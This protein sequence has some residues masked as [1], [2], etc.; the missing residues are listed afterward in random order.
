M[1][2]EP[3]HKQMN[4]LLAQWLLSFIASYS[5]KTLLVFIVKN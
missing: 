2:R 1:N 4:L 5:R 3:L